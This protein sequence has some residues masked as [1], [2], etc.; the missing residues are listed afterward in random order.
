MDHQ[1]LL[2]LIQAALPLTLGVA[3][4][5]AALMLLR[6]GQNTAAIR[7]RMAEINAGTPGLTAIPGGKTTRQGAWRRAG[8]AEGKQSHA[9]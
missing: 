9:A 5:A 3:L 4:V 8:S 1:L 6:R 2:N 7:R